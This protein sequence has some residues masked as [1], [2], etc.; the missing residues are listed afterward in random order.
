LGFSGRQFSVQGGLSMIGRTIGGY[1]EAP[2]ERQLQQIEEKQQEL[3]TLIERINKIIQ[4]NIP[5]LNELLI[6]NEIPHVFPVKIIKFN[7]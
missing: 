5:H 2:T 7:Q 3:K 6:A 1:S 4:E